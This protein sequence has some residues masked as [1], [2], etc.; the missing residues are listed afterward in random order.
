MSNLRIVYRA[1]DD[2]TPAD[3]ASALAQVY[4]YILQKHQDMQKG[5]LPDKSGPDSAKGGSSDS[6]A[7]GSIP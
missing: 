7:K 6:S 1:R 3:E 5:R 4:S 2:A